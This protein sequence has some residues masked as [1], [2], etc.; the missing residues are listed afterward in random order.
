MKLFN[1]LP[2][3][4]VELLHDYISWYG[5]CYEEEEGSVLPLTQMNY[6]LRFWERDKED[7]YKM[8]GEKF[9]IKKDVSF[10]RDR[11][12]LAEELNRL[13]WS[14]HA[15][16]LNFITVFNSKVQSFD[17][18]DIR[19]GLWQFTNLHTL[20]DN[21][22]NGEDFIIPAEMTVDKHPLQVNKGCKAI[23]MLGKIAKALNIEEGYEEF[24]QLHSQVLNQKKT[25]GK[26]CLSIHP[27]DF[28]TMS[29]NN[30]G[31]DSCMRWIG[32]AGDYRLGTIEMMN[33]PYV[34]IAYLESSEPMEVCNSF[35]N[36]KKWRQ[37]YVVTKDVILGNRQYPYDND[38]LQGAAIQWIKDLASSMPEFG[39]Y[40]TE[41][42]QISNQ[43][44][45][46][47]DTK[48]V[49]FS[50]NMGYMY[51]DIYDKRLAYVGTN[52]S[53]ECNYYLSGPA[54]C[55]G[56]GRVIE[57]NE[58][59]ACMVKC[60]ECNGSW[61]CESCGDWHTGDPYVVNDCCYCEWCYYN[62]FD[63]CAICDNS[64]HRSNRVFIKVSDKY[65]DSFY[66]ETYYVP[67]CEDC[68]D[69]KSYE[70]YF[71]PLVLEEHRWYGQRKYFMLENITDEGFEML[72]LH[73]TVI[74]S[75]KNLRDKIIIDKANFVE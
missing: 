26:L 11:N 37:L 4:D 22:Y 8:F 39:P 55:V 70:K 18:Y 14:E 50:F 13:L 51:N 47:I 23:K 28:L 53:E 3:E 33:S 31:W 60:Q 72:D 66:Q 10:T 44:W 9:I 49:H 41:A 2:S 19:H 71:G 34:I 38:D 61:R 5:D 63:R 25:R 27:L 43:S 73:P 68:Y 48:R 45:N 52:V 29:D 24:R 65:E 1:L 62:E 57:Y 17:S 30:C 15:K 35:W 54:V 7:F 69:D 20:A 58:V 67:I 46:T 32:D 16:S 64:T 6:F 21:I 42:C 59:D 74:Q 36:S 75:L 40:M 56:C 12:E